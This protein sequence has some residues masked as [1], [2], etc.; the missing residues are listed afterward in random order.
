VRPPKNRSLVV[1]EGQ[2]IP[3]WAR[4]I[5]GQLN[6]FMGSVSDALDKGLTRAENDRSQRKTLDFTTNASGA[7]P[8]ASLKFTCELSARPEEVR[9]A[10]VKGLDGAVFTGAVSVANWDMADGTTIRIN[11]V[12][13]LSPNSSYQ[14]VLLIS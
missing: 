7:A 11:E 4:K 10:Q 5:V 2:D 14:V 6:A 3:D 9:V 8:A 1:D 12:T 13:G